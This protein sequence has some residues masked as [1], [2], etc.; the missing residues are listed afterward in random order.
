MKLQSINTIYETS[1]KLIKTHTFS[2]LPVVKIIFTFVLQRKYKKIYIKKWSS[3][4][5]LLTEIL[6]L[7]ERRSGLG[8]ETSLPRC[9]QRWRSPWPGGLTGSGSPF[10]WAG[11]LHPWPVNIYVCR[12]NTSIEVLTQLTNHLKILFRWEKYIRAYR[13]W[14]N[15]QA[16]MRHFTKEIVSII[17]LH[18]KHQLGRTHHPYLQLLLFIDKF[19]AFLLRRAQV[20]TAHLIVQNVRCRIALYPLK[21]KNH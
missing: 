21:D 19:E 6:L 8:C 4:H 9:Y 5:D 1:L 15:P 12:A 11:H 2:K 17:K 14:A 18:T 16:K 3:E 10:S 13:N 7:L 20:N